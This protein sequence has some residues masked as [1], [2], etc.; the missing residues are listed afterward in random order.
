MET[1]WA[2]MCECVAE[3]WL[4]NVADHEDRL[5]RIARTLSKEGGSNFGRLRLARAALTDSRGSSTARGTAAAS[6]QSDRLLP[7]GASVC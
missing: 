5:L 6:R 1:S 3:E 4:P 7:Y 2:R